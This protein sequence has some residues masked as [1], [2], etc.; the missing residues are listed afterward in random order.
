[1]TEQR[2]CATD[3]GLLDYIQKQQDV[4]TRAVGMGKALETMIERGLGNNEA[5]HE[6][7]VVLTSTLIV[8]VDDHDCVNLPGAQS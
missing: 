2:A 1:M 4:A 6:L 3:A 8:L 5:T 7:A